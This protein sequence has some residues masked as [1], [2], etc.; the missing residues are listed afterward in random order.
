MIKRI[1][2]FFLV[3]L[4]LFY[5]W[6]GYHF[7]KKIPANKITTVVEKITTKENPA[8]YVMLKQKTFD[9]E[10]YDPGNKLL[11]TA[12]H[13]SGKFSVKINPQNEYGAEIKF[14][15]TE[16]P[17]LKNARRAEVTIHYFN[18]TNSKGSLWVLETDAENGT[19]L[20]WNAEGIPVTKGKWESVTFTF[21]ID[22]ALLNGL[23]YLKTY[24]WNKNKSEFFIDDVEIRIL[25]LQPEN[26]NFVFNPLAK[27]TF[28]YDLENDYDLIDKKT[29]STD[30]SHSGKHSSLIN[31]NSFS[32]TI[33]KRI[34]DVMND[35]IR[36][37]WYSVWLYPLIDKPECTLTMEI[38]NS[39]DEPVF[40]KGKTTSAM[41]LKA[42][43]WQK[44]NAELN[45]GAEDYS[46]LNPE[47]KILIYV[48]NNKRGKIYADDFTVSYGQIPDARGMQ[49]YAV[50]NPAVSYTYNRFHPPFKTTNLN[51]V[52]IG[53]NNSDHLIYTGNLKTG[54]AGPGSEIF[55]GN[56]S[57]LSKTMDELMVL[58]AN[59]ISIYHYC[60]SLKRFVISGEANPGREFSMDKKIITGDFNGDGK[61]EILLS[62]GD[63][64]FLFEINLSSVK[65]CI[66]NTTHSGLKVL[67]QGKLH[68]QDKLISG[69]F[70]GNDRSDLLE[71]NKDGNYSLNKFAGS[72]WKEIS[73]GNIDLGKKS[74]Q[75]SGNFFNSAHEQLLNVY[76]DKKNKQVSL[77]EFNGKKLVDKKLPG[78]KQLTEI[79]NADLKL[80]KL[81]N[82]DHAYEILA[83]AHDWRFECRIISTDDKGF[84]VS[85][86]PEFRGYN[87]DQN[88]KYYEYVQLLPGKF[89][90]N[91]KQILCVVSNCEDSDFDGIHC[92]K[93]ENLPDL[94]NSI[95]IYSFSK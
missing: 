28:Y 93:K 36:A 55:S 56:F 21:D 62:T 70:S 52:D 34:G 72:S 58:S 33:S 16:V 15:F 46:K 59:K 60:E 30:Y 84:L 5:A 91:E 79:F 88:P 22:Q 23:N 24:A 64:A 17:F 94:P 40:W 42:N 31:G 95:Q 81:K 87:A 65:R 66:D 19:A 11:T 43:Q 13:L 12:K 86:V 9:F 89:T 38:R 18:E 76:E 77:L 67:W 53:N 44:V 50:M 27:T 78:E 8:D 54:E 25:G 73:Y 39:D 10:V 61:S 35:T 82:T 20:N 74:I 75:V 1:F 51:R 90:G 83:Y 6:S 2:N 92:R 63:D 14:P 7:Y 49:T 29:I 85:S 32:V 57:G 41:S 80:M 47:D 48:V 69:Y 3:I 26:E 68:F 4:A 71:L 45:M 37:V